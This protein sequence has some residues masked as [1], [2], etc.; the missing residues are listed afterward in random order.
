[1]KKNTHT[2][3][4]SDQVVN[5]RA[6][7]PSPPESLGLTIISIRIFKDVLKKKFNLI[8]NSFKITMTP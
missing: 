3:G 1:M 7:R 4:S 8:S 5:L 2:V 6:G